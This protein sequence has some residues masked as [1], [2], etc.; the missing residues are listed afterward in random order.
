MG[1]KLCQIFPDEKNITY[2]FPQELFGM[3]CRFFRA[4]CRLELPGD[5]LGS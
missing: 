3:D 5:Q 1:D 2:A 4:G